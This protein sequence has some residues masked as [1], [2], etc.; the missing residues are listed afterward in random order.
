MST[1]RS[2]SVPPLPPKLF[3]DTSAWY[4]TLDTSEADHPQ[5]ALLANR[6]ANASTQLIITNLVRA[7]AHA[8]MLNRLGH[9]IADHFLKGLAQNPTLTIV[10]VTEQE[11][12]Q[13]LALLDR[14]QDK[15]FSL[16]DAASFLVMRQLHITHAFTFDRNFAQYGFTMLPLSP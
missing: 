11:E 8:L 1:R 13:A 6:I 14:Y 7:E 16:T 12:L 9:Y 5:A 3:V 10:H 2:R 15:D 4:A